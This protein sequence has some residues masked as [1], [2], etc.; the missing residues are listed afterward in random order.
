MLQHMQEGARS[1][2]R[3]SL[4]CPLFPQT[5]EDASLSELAV[6][7]LLTGAGTT[8][9]YSLAGA[10]A[11]RC[12]LAA[13]Q[14]VAVVRSREEE[15]AAQAAREREREEARGNAVATAAVRVQEALLCGQAVQCP[16]CSNPKRKDDACMHMDCDCGVHFCYVC[17]QDRYP[18]VVGTGP[19]YRAVNR[20]DCGC[21]RHSPYLHSQPGWGAFG[22]AELGESAA[23]GALIDFHRQRMAWFVRAAKES[24]AAAVWEEL[25]GRQAQVLEDVI[26]GRSIAWSELDH[27]EHPQL[28]VGNARHHALRAAE[29]LRARW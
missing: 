7:N 11:W 23:H 21:D 18:G 28:G 26:E 10:R 16:G 5:C 25:R 20:R 9:G 14:R 2:P 24:V 29:A 6:A 15:L 1:S 27:A 22:R 19:D 3:G 12:F 4:P 8:A 13:Q 17:G